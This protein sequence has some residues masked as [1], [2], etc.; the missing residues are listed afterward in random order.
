LQMQ[1]FHVQARKVEIQTLLELINE[2]TVTVQTRDRK[3]N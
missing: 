2:A 3:I 1:R